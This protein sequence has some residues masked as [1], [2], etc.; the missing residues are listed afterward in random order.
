MYDRVFRQKKQRLRNILRP[1]VAALCIF[2]TINASAQSAATIAAAKAAI[3]HAINI[4]NSN[5]NGDLP[6]AGVINDIAALVEGY[7]N[8][9]NADGSM[10]ANQAILLANPQ[11]FDGSIPQAQITAAYNRLA[12][13]GYLGTEADVATQLG[14]GLITSFTAAQREALLSQLQTG[15]SEGVALAANW[16]NLWQCLRSVASILEGQSKIR[17]GHLVYAVYDP[18]EMAGASLF[19]RTSLLGL[20]CN[21]APTLYG[22]AGAMVAIG[23]IGGILSGGTNV[24][25]DAAVVVGSGLALVVFFACP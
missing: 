6:T 16:T 3:T 14:G 13:N 24:A 10:A 9:A 18:Y 12:A 4:V 7:I 19:H 20:T 1:T 17:H 23:T 21:D 11:Y 22:V 15:G 8:D 2:L 5:Y 25:A